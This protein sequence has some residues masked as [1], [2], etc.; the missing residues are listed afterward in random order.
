M[1]TYW[2]RKCRNDVK[3]IQ[4]DLRILSQ[5]ACVAAVVGGAVTVSRNEGADHYHWQLPWSNYAPVL[6]SGGIA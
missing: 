2:R 6:H 5:R 4:S 1:P 3:G